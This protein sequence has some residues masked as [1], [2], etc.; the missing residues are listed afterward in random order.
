L[1]ASNVLGVLLD[2][3]LGKGDNLWVH[4]WGIGLD[5]AICGVDVNLDSF[6][7]LSEYLVLGQQLLS[8]NSLD[9]LFN[10]FILGLSMLWN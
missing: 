1:S 3:G 4:C 5:A 9:L 8:N 10:V 7:Y 6:E 2:V